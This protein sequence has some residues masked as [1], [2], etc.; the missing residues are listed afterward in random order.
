[1]MTK[2]APSKPH[3]ALIFFED[4]DDLQAYLNVCIEEYLE[5]GDFKSLG[6]SLETLIKAQDKVSGFSKKTNITRQHLHV[7]FKSK[8]EPKFYTMLKI[9]N[10]LG[11]ILNVSQK[12]K[13]AS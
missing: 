11:F 5:T 8:K 7:L 3:N 1:M 4:Q 2:H 9:F 12:H 10:E 6:E 13:K